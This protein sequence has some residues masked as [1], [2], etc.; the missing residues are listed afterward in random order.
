MLL[1]FHFLFACV[2]AN[3]ACLVFSQLLDEV[4]SISETLAEG[5]GQQARALYKLSE[6]QNERGM[7]AE[8][9]THMQK[10]LGL[11][12]KLKPD[13]EL[14]DAASEEA[15]SQLCPWMLW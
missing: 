5:N 1:V 4:V 15:F 11:L 6:I 3:G 2:L 8:S 9:S 12:A 7:L 13:S 10:A 14:K